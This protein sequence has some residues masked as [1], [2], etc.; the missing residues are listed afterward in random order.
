VKRS[1]SQTLHRHTAQRFHESVTLAPA[2]FDSGLGQAESLFEGP[3]RGGHPSEAPGTLRVLAQIDATYILAT[4]QRALILIDQH[5]AHE[6]VTFERLRAELR[7]GG[8]RVQP[9][10]APVP[11]E[12]RSSPSGSRVLLYCRR[13]TMARRKESYCGRIW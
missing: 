9:M 11:V 7:A 3:D 13:F 2:D 6:R 10:L 4:D 8:I 5:A 12:L 1:I